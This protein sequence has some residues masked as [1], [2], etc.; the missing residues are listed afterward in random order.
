MITK[1][2]NITRFHLTCDGCGEKAAIEVYGP[3]VLEKVEKIISLGWKMIP[4]KEFC[5]EC[6]KKENPCSP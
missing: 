3:S 6:L 4:D 5:P 1:E 2:E